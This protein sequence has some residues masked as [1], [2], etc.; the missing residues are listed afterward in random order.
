MLTIY[1]RHRQACKHRDEGR[2]YRHCHCPIWVDGFLDGKEMRESLKMRDWEKAQKKIRDWEAD[3]KVPEKVEKAE[4]TTIAK[5][6]EMFLADA[7][8]RG[9]KEPTI[10][11]HRIIFRQLE[12]FAEARAIRYLKQL[13]TE[14]LT[15]FRATWKGKS[16]LAGVKK[17]E[18]LKSFLRF[19]VAHQ[20]LDKNP[21]TAI[22]NPKVVMNPTLP[23]TEAEMVTI[24]TAALKRIDSV[25]SD[26]RNGARRLH[27]FSLFLRYTGLRIS[28]AVG[29]PVDRLQD[30]KLWLYTAKTGQHIYCP[31]PE[32]VVREL[33]SIPKVSERYW[34]WTGNGSLETA[35]KKWSEAL[36]EVFE[37]ANIGGHAHQ[38][39]D[40]FAVELLKAEVPIERVSILLGHASVRITEKHY[41]PWNRARQVQAE[42]DVQR[43]WKRDPMVILEQAGETAGTRN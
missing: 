13:S 12:A 11:R 16:A 39:R 43:A 14:T 3:G 30:G 8:A 19:C 20:W 5:A 9:L 15:E 17:L 36:A 23:F 26:G 6:K 18:R 42:A 34:F 10:D 1:R 28:D 31:L 25:R 33:D 4:P 38:F 22:R 27:A 37:D 24:R 29:C 21:A 35:R 32:F 7:E 2:E 40:T 41:N